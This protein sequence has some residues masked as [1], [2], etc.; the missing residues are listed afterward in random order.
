MK[1]WNK[2]FTTDEQKRLERR[3]VAKQKNARDRN[4]E[5][6]LNMLDMY[7]L[8]NKL[9]G[10]GKCDYTDLNFSTIIAGSQPD[11]PK[12]P[13][14]E[15]IDDTKGYVRGNVCVVMQRANQLKDNLVD[16]KTATTIID[17]IDRE[18]VKALML[19]MSKDHLEALKIKY[20]P[21]EDQPVEENSVEPVMNIG[22]NISVGKSGEVS[23]DMENPPV[24]A[25]AETIKPQVVNVPDDVA[26]AKAYAKYCTDFAEVGMKVSITYA[27]FKAKYVRK[28]CAL[29]G[30]PLNKEPKFILVLNLEVGFAKDNFIVVGD[31]IGKAITQMMIQTGL[32]V[33]K[34]A[35]MLNR[36]L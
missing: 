10:H 18:I 31:K 11:N 29:T 32:S 30:E 35:A 19:N 16:K 24:E 23:E 12:Y 2:L 33:P 6:T 20:L 17:P 7:L 13:T 14:I 21:D 36:A 8:G 9:L 34:I 1:D 15:R 27:Q 28:V 26:I 22:D 4:I 25:P 3:L 5:C